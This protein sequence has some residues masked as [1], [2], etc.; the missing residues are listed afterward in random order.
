MYAAF[1]VFDTTDPQKLSSKILLYRSSNSG[2]TYSGPVTVSQPLTRNQSPWIIGD[3]NNPLTVYIGWRVFANPLYPNLTNAIVG[4]RSTNGGASFTPAVPYPVA[5]LL[6]AFDQP[7]GNMSGPNPTLPSPRSAAY[8]TATI[9]G[10]GAIHVLVQEYVYPANHPIAL[11]R[12]LPLAPGASPLIG[13]PRV[14]STTSYNQGTT[15]TIRRAIDLGNGAGT[16]FMPMVTSVGEPGPSC[17]GN[18]GMTR[19]RVIAMYYDARANGVGVG[20]GTTGVVTGGDKQFDVRV[21][22]ASACSTNGLSFSPSE[23][24]S[25]YARSSQPPF[26][27]LTFKGYPQYPPN[28]PPYPRVNRGYTMNCAGNCSFAGD[29]IHQSP[30]NP[31]IRTASGAWKLTTAT[32]ATADRAKLPA[33]VVQLVWADTRDVLHPTD[34]VQRLAPA[35]LSHIDSLPWQEYV[36]PGTGFASCINPGA[37]DQNVYTAEYTP[38]GLYASAPVTFRTATIPRSYPL[39]I[40]N[41]TAQR[42]F[43]RVS[44]NDLS[45]AT[46]DYTDFDDG[47]PNFGEPL[48]RTSA[49]IIA[50]VSS[51]TGSVVV[52]PGVDTPISITVEETNSGGALIA[53]GAKTTVTLNTGGADASTTETVPAGDQPVRHGNQAV[54]APRRESRYWSIPVRPEWRAVPQSDAA[55]AEPAGAEPAGAEPAGA[56]PAGAE[57]AGAEP[58]GTQPAGAEPAG[59]EPAGAE[60]V[61]GRRDRV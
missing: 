49:I 56:E 37:R 54:L 55:G 36:T 8:P 26:D 52:G 40:E 30:R 45:N 43:Y 10:N 34:G 32:M 5:L 41:R 11:L 21:A 2:E 25:Q 51:V 3:Q 60:P 12:G 50:S 44:I 22:Q 31:Y 38:G 18:A 15:W 4:R 9:D 57:P 19:S 46:F 23:Q 48:A 27:V 13:V 16:Q 29:Y 24:V 6:K 14:T 58:A 53:G 28:Y 59:A 39:Y 1:V 47:S 7:Q 42:R 35:G 17:A 33:P 61:P 20:P